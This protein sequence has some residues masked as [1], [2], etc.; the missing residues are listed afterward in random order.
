MKNVDL[1]AIL[2]PI[3]DFLKRFRKPQKKTSTSINIQFGDI[4]LDKI[5]VNVY[6]EKSK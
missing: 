6:T 2:K 4:H 1:K 5:E 3:W